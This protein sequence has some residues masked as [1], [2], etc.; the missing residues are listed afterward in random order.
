GGRPI[1]E[2]LRSLGGTPAACAVVTGPEGGF[3][4]DEIAALRAVPAALPVG[5]GPRLL[6]ADT[7]A[8][9]ALA[10]WQAALGDWTRAPRAA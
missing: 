8:I 4:P 9:A 5:L 1:L 3:E 2:A 7:A 6:R 10:C